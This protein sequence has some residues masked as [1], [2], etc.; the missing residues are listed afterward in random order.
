ML[1]P[2]LVR[3]FCGGRVIAICWTLCHKFGLSLP[4]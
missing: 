2:L 4:G 3:S 1:M